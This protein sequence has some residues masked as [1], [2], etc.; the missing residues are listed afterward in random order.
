MLQTSCHSVVSTCQCALMWSL[1]KRMNRS[2]RDF[3]GSRLAWPCIIWPCTLAP[4]GGEYDGM[5]SAAATMRAEATITVT[6]FLNFVQPGIH[7]L[8]TH[9]LFIYSVIK[10]T[11]VCNNVVLQMISACSQNT[12][13]TALC[14]KKGSPTFLAITRAKIVWFL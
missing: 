11:N 5:L 10:C 7:I 14:H 6:T 8:S 4:L 3:E 1:Q 2:R 13:E 12:S 9:S